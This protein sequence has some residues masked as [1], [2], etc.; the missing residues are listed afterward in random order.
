MFTKIQV[1]WDNTPGAKG[2]YTRA[3]NEDEQ[4]LEDDPVEEYWG[5]NRNI[6]DSVIRSWALRFYWPPEGL[7]DQEIRDLAA[8]VEIRR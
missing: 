3:F 8:S 2:W 6:S 7:D 4:I 1:I 5:L